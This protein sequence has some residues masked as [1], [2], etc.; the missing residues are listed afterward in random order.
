MTAGYFAVTAV[1]VFDGF[2]LTEAGLLAVVFAFGL[3]ADGFAGVFFVFAGV[4]LEPPKSLLLL[5]R[6][7]PEAAAAKTK[8]NIKTIILFSERTLIFIVFSR[9]C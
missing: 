4:G 3:A 1:E 8:L 9:D 2:F 6:S 7:W 5:P